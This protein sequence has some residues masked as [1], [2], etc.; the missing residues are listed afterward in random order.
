M[1]DPRRSADPDVT[2]AAVASAPVVALIDPADGTMV[3]VPLLDPSIHPAHGPMGV[4]PLLD[5]PVRPADVARD[6][7][8]A[9]ESHDSTGPGVR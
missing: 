6:V 2:A 8:A 1:D 4:V 5:P 7:V 9:A 3:V